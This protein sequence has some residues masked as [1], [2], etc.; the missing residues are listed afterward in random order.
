MSSVLGLII[1]SILGIFIFELLNKDFDRSIRN[2]VYI[3]SS[4]IL[5]SN[6]I[7]IIFSRLFFELTGSIEEYL[8]YYPIFWVKYVL[9]S[10]IVNFGLS[11]IFTMV[12]KYIN[13]S[14]EVKKNEN[15]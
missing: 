3:F 4:F 11:I 14:I 2:Y 13:I 15:D 10:L 6:F 8:N 9:L 5:F 1:P 12:R 7:S